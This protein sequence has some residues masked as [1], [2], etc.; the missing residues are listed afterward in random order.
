MAPGM[1][2]CWARSSASRISTSST[3]PPAS[4]AATAAGERFSMRALA[5]AIRWAAVFEDM[6]L[7]PSVVSESLISIL[8]SSDD[9]SD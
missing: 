3:A 6:S 5:S 2:P 7:T 8:L 9:Q 1:P 4:S